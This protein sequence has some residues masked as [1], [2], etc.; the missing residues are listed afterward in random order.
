MLLKGGASAVRP[1]WDY[2]LQATSQPLRA[3]GWAVSEALSSG[4]MEGEE[5]ISRVVSR[6]KDLSPSEAWQQEDKTTLLALLATN[7]SVVPVLCNLQPD[8]FADTARKI[9]LQLQPQD[10]PGKRRREDDASDNDEQHAAKRSRREDLERSVLQRLQALEEMQKTFC[11]MSTASESAVTELL[12]AVDLTELRDR[13]DLE[14]PGVEFRCDGLDPFPMQ[15]YQQETDS[16]EPFKAR[17]EATLSQRAELIGVK[18]FEVTIINNSNPITVETGTQLFKGFMDLAVAP[19]ALMGNSIIQQIRIGLEL[20][21][22][23]EQKRAHED[24]KGPAGTSCKEKAKLA[25][26]ELKAKP[27]AQAYLQLIACCALAEHPL[28][29]FLTDGI[30]CHR[31]RLSGRGLYV[32]PDLRPRQAL[33]SMTKFLAKASTDPLFSLDKDSP[34]CNMD[35]QDAAALRRMRQVAGRNSTLQYGKELNSFGS[36]G[37]EPSCVM[38]HSVPCAILRTDCM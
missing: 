24:G 28:I 9:L 34:A 7:Q 37:Q 29:I 33:F 1:L 25:G 31:M 13:Q 11:Q 5:Q 15:A 6:I 2:N 21:H 19:S 26:L 17:L 20:K 16:Y 4:A 14:E 22:T 12:R 35:Q 36:L 18:G 32:H 10:H 3:Y 30:R 8:D 38:L 23:D 27:K